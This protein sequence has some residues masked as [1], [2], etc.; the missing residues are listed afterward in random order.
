MRSIPEPQ[1]GDRPLNHPETV[2]LDPGERATITYTAKQRTAGGF[3]LPVLAISKHPESVYKAQTDDGNVIYPEASV[4][5]TD[6]DDKSVT[7]L[8]G[9]EFDQELEVTI[10]NL[11]QSTREYTS[12]PIGFEK[13][14]ESRAD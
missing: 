11:S 1:P 9:Y 5:P 10:S 8:P 13:G 2:V 7:F 4:P 14:G 3:V 6:V 12:Q